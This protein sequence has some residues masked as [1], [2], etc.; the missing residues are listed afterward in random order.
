MG[1]DI[2]RVGRI[3]L[4]GG[5]AVAVIFMMRKSKNGGNGNSGNGIDTT[6]YT[7]AGITN[8]RYNASYNEYYACQELRTS[9]DYSVYRV[10]K[11]DAQGV[12]QPMGSNLTYGIDQAGTYT[13]ATKAECIQ[14]VNRLADRVR[15]PTLAPEPSDEQLGIRPTSPID[16]AINPSNMMNSYSSVNGVSSRSVSF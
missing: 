7:P 5:I 13:Y 14:E 9:S 2:L 3:I 12:Y 10:V 6:D 4:F 8:E 15:P 11:K 16:Y 1:L